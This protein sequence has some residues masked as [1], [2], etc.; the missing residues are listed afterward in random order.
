MQSLTI[1]KCLFIIR[2]EYST[3]EGLIYVVET[4]LALLGKTVHIAPPQPEFHNP[5]TGVYTD[6]FE[7][8]KKQMQKL[9]HMYWGAARK[10]EEYAR[11]NNIKQGG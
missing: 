3:V 1:K 7:N 5:I 9:F 4:G 2:K 10:I 11:E 8:Y 6:P